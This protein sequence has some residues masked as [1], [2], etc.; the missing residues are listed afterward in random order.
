VYME[1]EPGLA[2]GRGVFALHRR[3]CFRLSGYVQGRG[4][5]MRLFAA[6]TPVMLL[7][8]F[9]RCAM[10]LV[11]VRTTDSCLSTRAL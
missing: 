5:W 4:W 3:C 9:R 6:P 10:S 7:S 2:G 1:E 11:R 8:A